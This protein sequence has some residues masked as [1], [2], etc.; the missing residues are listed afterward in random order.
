MWKPTEAAAGGAEVAELLG[1]V[2]A[3]AEQLGAPDAA[4]IAPLP[5]TLA[6]V[7]SLPALREFVARYG[8][9]TLAGQEWPVILRAWQLARAGHARE[10]IALDHEWGKQMKTAP[11]A[12]ASFRVGRRQLNKLRALRHERVIQ[13]YLDAIETGQAHGWHPVVYGVVL[14]V[15]HLPLRQGLLNFA[16]QTLAG[17]VSATE[18]A[19]R[20]PVGECASLLQFAC[21]SLPAQLPALPGAAPFAAR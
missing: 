14:A 11:F 19:H 10:L 7:K 18:R 6:T 5:P 1:D 21:E 2:R 12:E 16:T 13:R 8:A 4:A 3:L 9:E 20:L 17:L 15:Y